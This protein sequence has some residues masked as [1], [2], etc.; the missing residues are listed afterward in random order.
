MTAT[1]CNNTTSFITIMNGMRCNTRNVSFDNEIV[2]DTKTDE[3]TAL[4]CK[5]STHNL[6]QDT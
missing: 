2:L 3:F 1:W 5:V 6:N 4:I